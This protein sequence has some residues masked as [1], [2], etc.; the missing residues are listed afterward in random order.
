MEL[1]ERRLAERVEQRVLKRLRLYG[2]IAA[3]AVSVLGYVGIHQSNVVLDELRHQRDQAQ[4]ALEDVKKDREIVNAE[5]NSFR[6][7]VVPELRVQM[8]RWINLERRVAL[9]EKCER[10]LTASAISQWFQGKFGRPMQ[11][12][13]SPDF[14]KYLKL[15]NF[16]TIDQDNG[17]YS[18]FSQEL[19]DRLYQDLLRREPDP[20]GRFIWGFRLMRGYTYEEV[21]EEIRSSKEAQ[22]KTPQQRPPS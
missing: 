20:F 12:W 7:T 4:Q 17:V 1:L 2:S 16:C 18:H 11:S 8:N 21:A 15:Y 5:V 13:E 19:V 10:P 14:D 22:A 6:E 9:S 3:V